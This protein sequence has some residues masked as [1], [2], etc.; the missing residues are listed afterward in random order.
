MR[1]LMLSLLLVFGGFCFGCGQE[2]EPKEPTTEEAAEKADEAAEKGED[3]AEKMKDE[4]EKM[5][6]E[7]TE[8]AEDMLE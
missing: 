3:E 2:G 4:A 5:K 6:D 1:A 8:K 7:A